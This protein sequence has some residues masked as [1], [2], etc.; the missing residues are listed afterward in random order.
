M[1][2]REC[3]KIVIWIALYDCVAVFGSNQYI[4]VLKLKNNRFILNI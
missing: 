4:S 1:N 2:G 3:W